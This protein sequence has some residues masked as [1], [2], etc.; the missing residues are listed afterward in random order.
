MSWNQ[1]GQYPGGQNP[2]S[3]GQF[4][5]QGGQNPGGWQQPGQQQQPGWQQQPQQ[6][7]QSQQQG[8]QQPQQPRQSGWQGQQQQQPGW[9]QQ[10]QQSGWQGQ[11]AGGFGQQGAGGFGGGGFGAPGAGFPP[12]ASSGPSMGKVLGFVGGGLAIVALVAVLI[13]VVVGKG[14][15]ST[16]EPVPPPPVPSASEPEPSSGPSEDP[17]PSGDSN[18][19]SVS[20]GGVSFDPASGWDVKDE[21]SDSVLMVRTSPAAGHTVV[22]VTDS[23]S[24][25]TIA[26]E[27]IDQYMSTATNV[28]TSPVETEDKGDLDVAYTQ[29]TGTLSDGGGSIEVEVFLMVI[30]NPNGKTMINIIEA[31]EGDLKSV[32]ESGDPEDVINQVVPQL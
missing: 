24:A 9:Q 14:G 12:P 23:S 2:Q 5:N 29:S 13:V 20:V 17:S 25:S 3:G 8:W 1:Y 6:P 22:V 10:P 18:S 21:K 11:Q 31:E 19:G 26:D 4:P 27:A 30:Q 32:L 28:S 7:Q 15:S 16:P